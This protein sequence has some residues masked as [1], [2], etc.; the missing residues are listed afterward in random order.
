MKIGVIGSRSITAANFDGLD[1]NQWDIVVTGGAT[2]VDSLIEEYCKLHG[3][4]V[5]V[6]KPD[7]RLGRGAPHIRNDK[8]I[9]ESDRIIAMWD[10]KSK[11]TKSVIEKC[12]RSGKQ[13]TVIE[14]N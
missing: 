8:I 10:G 5:K 1:I 11:G 3:I 13:I 2:G 4:R 9:R 12:K 6:Y 7:Y 14:V